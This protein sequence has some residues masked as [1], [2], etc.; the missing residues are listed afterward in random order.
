MASLK[1]PDGGATACKNVSR[2]AR[3]LLTNRAAVVGL[4]R[5]G[6]DVL[7]LTRCSTPSCVHAKYTTTRGWLRLVLGVPI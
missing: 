3:E 1:G 2:L 4:T 5:V 6:R 7:E